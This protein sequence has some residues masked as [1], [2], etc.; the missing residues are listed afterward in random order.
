[1]GNDV[2]PLGL[3]IPTLNSRSFLGTTI[4]S[5]CLGLSR[6]NLCEVVIVDDGSAENLRDV[7]RSAAHEFQA[8]RFRLIEMARNVGQTSA[9]TIGLAYST[10]AIIVTVDDDL[11]FDHT[12]V[13]RV[14][15]AATSESDFVVASP[16]TYGQ[17]K[18]RAAASSAIRRVAVK[19]LST[20][21][22]FVFSSL[23]AYRHEFVDRIRATQLPTTELGW[24]FHLTSR[25]VNTTV[26]TSATGERRSHS[27]YG[28]KRLLRTAMPLVRLLGGTFAKYVSA[29]AGILALLSVLTSIYYV[30]V[31]VQSR[32]AVPGFA[33]LSVIGFVNLSLL[34]FILSS[35]LRSRPGGTPKDADFL[36]SCI[37]SSIQY[38][39]GSQTADGPLATSIKVG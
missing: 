21:G 18:V 13:I 1:M 11:R 7:V 27:N 20:P 30:I 32:S 31:A 25:Y 6:E 8:I 16:R 37:R 38:W 36:K 3:V 28:F 26:D 10:S 33:T 19:A 29:T 23:V 12:A 2:A 4:R 9:T 5:L 15:E 24:M 34:L 22:D 39:R 14:A 35:L 17:S